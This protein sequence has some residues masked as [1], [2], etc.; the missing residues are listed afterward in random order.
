[1]LIESLRMG[2]LFCQIYGIKKLHG[3]GPRGIASPYENFV[4]YPSTPATKDGCIKS[5]FFLFH[6]LNMCFRKRNLVIIKTTISWQ[7]LGEYLRSQWCDIMIKGRLNYGFLTNFQN[8]KVA[9]ANKL[10]CVVSLSVHT[11]VNTMSTAG[12]AF[13]VALDIKQ[14]FYKYIVLITSNFSSQ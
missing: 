5:I 14:V 9:K 7:F 13:S 1:M 10:H 6:T 8:F 11:V 12:F 4:E 2:Y 3:I